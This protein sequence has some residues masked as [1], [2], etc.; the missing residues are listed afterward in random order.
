MLVRIR[1]SKGSRIRQNARKNQH[2]ALGLASLLTPSAIMAFV[3][4][5][6]RL[7]ADL[8]AGGPFPISV[9]L[10]SHWQVWL[11][12]AAVLEFFALLLNR[13]GNAETSLQKAVEE[14]EP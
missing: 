10:F 12:G 13:Y 5:F 2:L 1:L 6:W 11:A 7:S 14:S 4:A 9:G 8:S 3:L